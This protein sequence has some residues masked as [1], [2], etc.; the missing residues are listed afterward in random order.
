MKTHLHTAAIVVYI[1]YH[2]LGSDLEPLTI[3]D[4][5][6]SFARA[7][8]H[9]RMRVNNSAVFRTLIYFNMSFSRKKRNRPK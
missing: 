9:I 2:N 3:L 1:L 5:A 8:L 7:C 4:G 6:R